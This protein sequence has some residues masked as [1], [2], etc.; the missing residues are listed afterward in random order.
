M[1][2]AVRAEAT[3]RT[4][5]QGVALVRDGRVVGRA[6]HGDEVELEVRVPGRPT[7]FEV[8]L[9]LAAG[10]W[11]CDCSSREPVC[12]HVVAAVIAL[13]QAGGEL[14]A[15]A[16]A[17]GTI[18]YLLE[19]DPGGV[20]V[21]RAIVHGDRVEPLRGQLMSV[22]AGPNDLAT[23]EADLL[24]DQI[25]GVRAA[26]ASGEKLDRLLAVLEAARDVRWRGEPVKT[27]GEPVMPRAVVDD[28]AD[29]GVRVRIE[30]DP[31]VAA[32]I[33][34][35][36][37]RTKA[38][39]LRPIGAVDL[40]GAR[41]EKLPQEFVVARTG[42]PELIGKTLPALAQRIAID[43]R[44][45]ALPKLGAREEPRMDFDVAQDGDRL[46]VFPTLVYGDPP[47]ARVD[48]RTLVH[49][50]GALPI[51]DE[52]A[53]R[54]L[55]HRL[56]DE[57]NLVPGRRVEVVGREAFLMQQ[58]LAT[59]L[60]TDAKAANA[61]KA[62]DLAVDVKIDGDRVDAT[63]TGAGDRAT[64]IGLALR[65]WQ[66]GVDLVPLSGGGWGRLPMAWFDAHGQRLADLLASRGNDK[67]MPIYALPDLAR[68]CEDLDR[69]PPPELDRL[70]PLLAGFEHIAT[71]AL[72]AGF[73][74]EL[75]P[76]QQHGVDWL[77]F[78]RDAGLGCVLADDMGLGKTIQ[79]LAV[80]RGKTL[81]V[82][83]KSVLFNWQAEAARFRPDL[84][85]ALYSGAKRVLDPA[86]D[87]VLTSYPIL[88]ND[89]DA[90]AA[91]EW[92]TVI[93]DESQ[94]IKNPDSQVAR[95]A[96]RLRGTWRLTLSGTPVENRLD[97]LWSQLH[98]TNPGLLG[99][100]ADFQERWSEPI[101]A[102][103]TFAAARLRERIRPFVLRRMKRD[104]ARELPPRTDQILYVE[105][106]ET[107]RITYDA[108]RAATQR[109]IVK[110]LEAGGGV[111]AALEALLRL[112]QAACH[113]ALLPGAVRGGP[114]PQSSSKLERLMDALADAAADG[115]R[116]LVF[117][118]WTSL[119]DLIEPH[120]HDGN[121]P[122][123]RLDGSTIDRAGV[124]EKFQAD[125]GPPVMLLSLKAGGTGLN[126]TAADH[127]FLV[128]PWWNPAVE[129]Q[130]ADRAH[131]IGQDKPVMVYRLVAKG[132][133]EERILELQER[134]R[135][136]ADAALSEA[137]GATAI[138]RDDLL[139][140]L[141]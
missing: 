52:D 108:I 25:I 88:R 118:Q 55:V 22:L 20:R 1:R 18:R 58:G 92:D 139:A 136:L 98:F 72:P 10:E 81:V 90:L 11:Q 14:P 3:E 109:E 42:L 21:E 51:R 15:S 23:I 45:T 9:D 47:R 91:V 46:V 30:A 43:V 56:R 35:G 50:A 32:V 82:S 85:V 69:P 117:S 114:A 48:G 107:E 113:G 41:M 127:V 33:A 17:S 124:V 62:I 37:A 70:R 134:K 19:P 34:V 74:G 126:L 7:P 112:R 2:D 84:R 28:A 80:V 44:A 31:E 94:T 110:L 133:V 141:A 128:D 64:S 71:A 60:R 5:S 6:R 140:L 111:M 77:V 93:L 97:E 65:A 115:H 89:I 100:R 53:E 96:Y 36:V 40:V 103:D 63:V 119:L 116:A 38:G 83:P 29:G 135:G 79:A 121:L 27:Y 131:R 75:R 76:Y 120:L 87:I 125:D 12:S 16:R 68:L 106:D 99:G 4:W 57:L 59:W 39:V 130:A 86:A 13:E 8:V 102:G 129:D 95:A 49:L 123:V 66:A 101:V 24:A 54:R 138:T 73:R 122:F 67:R 61:A 132:T 78:C 26:P 137:G 105:L 104:V